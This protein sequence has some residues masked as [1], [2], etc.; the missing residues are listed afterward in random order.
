VIGKH[1][2]ANGQVVG[3]FES[4]SLTDV[5][6]LPIGGIKTSTGP[7]IAILSSDHQ[8]IGLSNL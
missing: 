1:I 5:R 8:R 7:N 4:G 6:D 3:V 2:W